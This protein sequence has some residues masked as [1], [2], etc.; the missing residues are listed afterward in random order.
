M[1]TKFEIS[2]S[3]CS[4][5]PKNLYPS[6]PISIPLSIPPAEISSSSD[7]NSSSSRVSVNSNIFNGNICN[8]NYNNN[9]NVLESRQLDHICVKKE[10]E[11]CNRAI[12]EY[13]NGCK[14][15]QPINGISEKINKSFKKSGAS[16]NE[17]D[18]KQNFE[19]GKTRHDI[20]I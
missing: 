14:K 20:K 4:A 19:N 5:K 15:L 7:S 2:S 9:N 12:Y 1:H 11:S 3:S 6:L 18:N 17:N 16:F 8:K 13:V 10:I